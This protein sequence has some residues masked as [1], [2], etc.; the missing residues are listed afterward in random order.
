MKVIRPEHKFADLY[1]VA[2]E[3]ESAVYMACKE[4]HGYIAVYP[5]EPW[6]SGYKRTHT[7]GK[8]WSM[9]VSASSRRIEGAVGS[10]SGMAPYNL[11]VQGDLQTGFHHATGWRTVSLLADVMAE[12][13]ARQLRAIF[14]N[15]G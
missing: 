15:A 13:L 6:W 4:G 12:S 7:L 1:D 10:S 14:P 11:Y 3:V 5:P 2:R 8:S 9:G